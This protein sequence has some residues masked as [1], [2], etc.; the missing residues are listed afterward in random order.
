MPVLPR[1][2]RHKVG[3]RALYQREAFQPANHGH[4]EFT[5]DHDAYVASLIAPPLAEGDGN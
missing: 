4:T 5:Y 1:P 2:V 3:S